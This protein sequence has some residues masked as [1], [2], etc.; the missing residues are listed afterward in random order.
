ME[1]RVKYIKRS[2]V[3]RSRGATAYNFFI[4][5]VLWCHIT[6]CSRVNRHSAS[7]A[8]TDMILYRQYNAR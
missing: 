3:V 1:T 6:A 4:S 7:V 8:H 2:K 5:Y